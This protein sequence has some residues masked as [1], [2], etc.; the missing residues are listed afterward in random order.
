MTSCFCK[1]N[2]AKRVLD[3]P[4]KL[5]LKSWIE[6]RVADLSPTHVNAMSRITERYGHK[7]AGFSSAA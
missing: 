1:H 4:S 3:P 5:F 6:D 7:R 2:D